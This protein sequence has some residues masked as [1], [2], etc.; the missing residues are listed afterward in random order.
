MEI[1]VYLFTGFL[2]SGKTTFIQD[3]LCDPRFN[4]GE[5]TL[6][7]QCEEGE[8]E[9][10]PAPYPHKNVYVEIIDDQDAVTTEQLAVLQKKYKAQ[11]VV[12]ELNG[13]KLVPDFLVKMPENWVIYQEIMFADANTILAYN[14]NM[15]NLVVDKLGGC[16][17]V[18]FNRVP[19]D[20][21]I[22]PL[23]KLARAVSRKVDIVYDYA[24]GHTQFDEI[25]D[26]LPFD[27]NAPVIEIED[28]DYGLFYR[29][30]MDESKKYSGKKVR[31]KAQVAN[32]RREKN[33][34][35]A[36]GR[37]VMTCCIEDIRFMGMPCA[38]KD[39]ASLKL[40][41]WVMVEGKIEIRPHY[42]YKESGG[43]GPVLVASSV[44]PAEGCSPEYCTF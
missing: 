18:V 31:F 36:P 13:M 5:R 25:E 1:P 14:N 9:Y 42:L 3:T 40:R 11:R 15:R 32:L 4:A 33:G 23:H 35:F 28:Q 24:D 12:V 34:F 22:M 38:W 17:M 30:L 6:L 19:A 21:D 20:M 10:D 41:S 2:D 16:E 37:F 26:P 27:I 29:D 8:E 43:M 7:L 39:S 44:T